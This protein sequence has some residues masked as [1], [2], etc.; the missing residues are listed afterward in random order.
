MQVAMWTK[1]PSLPRHMPLETAKMAPTAFIKRTGRESKDGMEKPERIVLI[2][3]M[4]EP[5]AMYIVLPAGVAGDGAGLSGETCPVFV[6]GQVFAADGKVLLVNIV[7]L[8]L[9]TPNATAMAV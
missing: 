4:P 9:S 6:V 3:G 7:K 8:E 1:G 2:S 5:E